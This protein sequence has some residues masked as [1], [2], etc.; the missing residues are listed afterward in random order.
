M[1]QADIQSDDTHVSPLHLAAGSGSGSDCVLALLRA[2]AYHGTKDVHGTTPLMTA[3]KVGDTDTVSMLARA[4]QGDG[5][6]CADH[7][8]RSALFWAAAQGVRAA[9]WCLNACH[10]VTWLLPRLW[11]SMAHV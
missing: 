2:G 3:A 6:V 11:S 1:C 10:K 8:G 4:V 5:L 7:L 9:R